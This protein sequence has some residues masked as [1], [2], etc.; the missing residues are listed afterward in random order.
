MKLTK[1]T[2]EKLC[3]APVE[4]KLYNGNFNRAS[5]KINNNKVTYELHVSDTHEMLKW[6][7]IC[8]EPKTQFIVW[9]TSCTGI[10]CALPDELKELEQKLLESAK[11]TDEYAH[12]L[13]CENVA[14]MAN[15]CDDMGW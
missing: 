3:A 6:F 7:S 15:F 9:Y 4:V 12:N 13:W 5:V 11:M 2:L 10:H 14:A 1:K 8:K